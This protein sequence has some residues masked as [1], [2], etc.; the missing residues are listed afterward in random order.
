MISEKEY[1]QIR[2]DCK[3]MAWS[4]GYEEFHK[5]RYYKCL[6]E[7]LS[8]QAYRKYVLKIDDDE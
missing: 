7:K 3:I 2:R 5:E 8:E 6:K 4:A 1:H